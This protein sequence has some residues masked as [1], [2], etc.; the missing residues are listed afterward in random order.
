MGIRTRIRCSKLWNLTATS[1]DIKPNVPQLKGIS[2]GTSIIDRC[3]HRKS[4]VKEALIKGYLD[5]VSARRIEKCENV[6]TLAA[7]PVHEDGY[8]EVLGAAEGLKEDK[9]CWAS[10]FR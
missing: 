4:S 7:I 1:V 6:S 9:A 5:G 8:R 10:L 2:F 3:R